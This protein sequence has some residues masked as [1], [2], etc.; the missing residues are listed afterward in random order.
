MFPSVTSKKRKNEKAVTSNY[1]KKTT[2]I[3]IAA[4]VQ[5][6]LTEYTK[7]MTIIT[8]YGKDSASEADGSS[9]RCKKK[10]WNDFC[11]SLTVNTNS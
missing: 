7:I 8:G 3:I 10:F 2:K 1:W 9:S 11:F 4:M 6:L 5:F